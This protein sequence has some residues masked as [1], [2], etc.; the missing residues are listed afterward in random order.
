M[1]IP[2]ND[3]KPTVETENLGGIPGWSVGDEPAAEPSLISRTISESVGESAAVA[4]GEC[5]P[6]IETL[7]EPEFFKALA[8]PSRVAILVELA[9]RG[10][11][12]TVTEL[13]VC[14]PRDL[15]VVSRHLT[16]LRDAGVVHSERRGK[17]VYYRVRVFDV[18]ERMSSIARL[19]KEL[20]S[21]YQTS[22]AEFAASVG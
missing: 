5:C 10:R 8:D 15:S 12:C 22:N 2:R 14:C 19:L 21:R 13:S 3:A 9:R 18:A 7:F 6:G 1:L 4:E 16:A 17:K 20:A 11:A